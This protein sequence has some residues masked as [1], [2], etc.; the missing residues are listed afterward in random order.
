[1]RVPTDHGGPALV[2]LAGPTLRLCNSLVLFYWRAAAALTTIGTCMLRPNLRSPAFAP[3][4]SQ[5]D[6]SYD[7]KELDLSVD[8]PAATRGLQGHDVT[9]SSAA[10]NMRLWPAASGTST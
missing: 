4:T 6:T 9:P 7:G 3:S 5:D 10:G 2:A 1:M 8:Q